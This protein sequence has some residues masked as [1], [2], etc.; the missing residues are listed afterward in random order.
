[1]VSTA[2]NKDVNYKAE[3]ILDKNSEISAFHSPFMDKI[4]PHRLINK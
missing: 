3:G 1:M 2:R 4:V